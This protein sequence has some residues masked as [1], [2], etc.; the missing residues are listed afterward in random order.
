[1]INKNRAAICGLLILCMV[2]GSISCGKENTANEE[3]S[4]N[5]SRR[6]GEETAGAYT[7]D[8]LDSV[9]GDVSEEDKGSP[10]ETEIGLGEEVNLGNANRPVSDKVEEVQTLSIPEAVVMGDGDMG[11]FYNNEEFKDVVPADIDSFSAE[12]VPTKYDSRNVDGKRYVTAVEDQG[13]SYL[14]WAFASIG[15]IE[16]DILRHNEDISYKDL[17][18]SEKHLAYYNL[19]SAEGSYQGLIDRDYRELVN[20]EDEEDAWVFDYDT[21]YIA[22]GG[23]TDFCTSILTAWKGPVYEEDQDAFISM[24]G[25]SYLFTDNATT[26]SAAYGGPFHV[27]GVYEVPGAFENNL[28]IKQMIMEHGAASI[29]VAASEKFWKNHYSSLYSN[30]GGNKVPTADHEVLIIGW[31]DD[32]PASN[33]RIN[34]GK[35]GAWLCKNSWGSS[36]GDGGFFYLSYY[37][38][39]VAISN[40]SAYSVAVEGDEDFYDNNYQAAG[41]MTDLVSSFDDSQNTMS[42]LSESTNPYGMLYEAES[43]EALEAI[44]FM[45]L[46]LY[47]QYELEIYLNPTTKDDKIYFDEDTLPTL[48]QKLSAIS[49]GFHTFELDRKIN[50]NAGDEFFILIKPVTAGRLV[51]EAAKDMISDANYDEWKNLTGNVHNNYEASGLS[52]YISDDGLSLEKQLDKDFFLKAYTKNR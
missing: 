21:G 18:L 29:G 40:A 17:D 33:F 45:S 48:S 25:S 26:P 27:Q 6:D 49:G 35:N 28:L 12:D 5:A 46:D 31:D 42:T 22:V 34:P 52:Y 4:G 2:A 13:Y 30:Y 41:F 15:A 1:M 38:E 37:D 7:D 11:A 36:T 43:D 9:I 44:G 20:A 3:P 8:D 32:Y 14:C 50:L 51:Y 24:Y 23:V 39:T 19:H 10:E 47:Q 16:S